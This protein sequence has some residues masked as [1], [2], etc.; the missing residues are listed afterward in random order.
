MQ[1]PVPYPNITFNLAFNTLFHQTKTDLKDIWHEGLD[2]VRG[3]RVSRPAAVP[4][5]AVVDVDALGES[6]PGGVALQLRLLRR[7][8]QGR[9]PAGGLQVG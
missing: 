9:L 8:Q 2:R 6:D 5:G 1:I 3:G 4:A 7:G